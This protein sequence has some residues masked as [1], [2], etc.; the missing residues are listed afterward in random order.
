ME[1]K[2]EIATSAKATMLLALASMNITPTKT[3]DA[4]GVTTITADLTDDQVK[5]IES[6][7]N[8]GG[9]TIGMVIRDGAN[10]VAEV[11]TD[12]VDFAVNDL[13]IP[14]ATIGVKAGASVGRIAVKAVAQT[15]ASIINNVVDEG[16]KAVNGV[17]Q[18]DECMK[19]KDS[20]NTVK[21]G[22]ASLFAKK[23]AIKIS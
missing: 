10:R 13:A 4:N 5:T 2:I 6:A 12:G 21:T 17:K 8:G 16:V 18:N 22:V 20:W 23:P 11:V 7:F 19:L 1:K 9:A 15:G 3:E 14:V